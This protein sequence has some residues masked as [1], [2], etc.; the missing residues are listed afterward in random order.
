M[1]VAQLTPGVPGK[2]VIPSPGAFKSVGIN[3]VAMLTRSHQRSSGK[4]S[5]APL[6]E[7]SLMSMSPI[8][9]IVCDHD[10]RKPPTREFSPTFN[11]L[12]LKRSEIKRKDAPS[13]R[14]QAAQYIDYQT[15][16][17]RMPIKYTILVKPN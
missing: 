15:Q 10:P 8:R 6:P 2:S 5:G 7:G 14:F 9:K 3:A 12:L 16:K 13:S 17:S 4:R 11:P 1:V